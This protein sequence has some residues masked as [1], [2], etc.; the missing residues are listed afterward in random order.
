M[1]W[2][3]TCSDENCSKLVALSEIEQYFQSSGSA[4]C[5]RKLYEEYHRRDVLHGMVEKIRYD[6]TQMDIPFLIKET[7]SAIFHQGEVQFESNC[8]QQDMD[9]SKIKLLEFHDVNDAYE[10][11]AQIQELP[12]EKQVQAF[13]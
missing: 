12:E 4:D 1:P 8:C 3:G 13:R 5:W 11:I 10:W 2:D 6:S 7:L 9:V